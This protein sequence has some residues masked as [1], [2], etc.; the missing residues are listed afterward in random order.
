MTTPPSHLEYAPRNG[1]P[2]RRLRW[3]VIVIL[4]LITL[5]LAFRTG[6]A[7]YERM[8]LNRQVRA[9][10]RYQAPAIAFDEAATGPVPTVREWSAVNA[11]TL[12][13]YGT[14]FLHERHLPDGRQCLVGVDLTDL[15]HGEP[16]IAQFIARVH[17]PA[18]T[19]SVPRRLSDGFLTLQLDKQDGSVKFM[20]GQIDPNDATHFT[21]AYTVNDRAGVIDGWLLNDGTVKLEERNNPPT[22]QTSRSRLDQSA[23]S[24]VAGV[25]CEI[26]SIGGSSNAPSERMSG[27]ANAAATIITASVP[28]SGKYADG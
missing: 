1:V 25:V 19:F 5:P 11:M 2:R 17:E 4:T 3:V 28:K 12:V 8:V 7:G 22:T 26:G 27:V 20:G 9:C 23:G 14:L 13:T 15:R 6:R 18:A 10:L 21:I 16:L 24:T